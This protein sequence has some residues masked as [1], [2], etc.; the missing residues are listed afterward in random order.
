MDLEDLQP[1][2]ESSGIEEI[3]AVSLSFD[4]EFRHAND[5]FFKQAEQLEGAAWYLSHTPSL[6]R[7]QPSVP[8]WFGREEFRKIAS[9]QLRQKRRD[10]KLMGIGLSGRLQP[11]GR[12]ILHVEL[13]ESK[14]TACVVLLDVAFRRDLSSRFG[15]EPCDSFIDPADPGKGTARVAI[16]SE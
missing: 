11:V 13:D 2:V 12:I 7:H 5:S 1:L 14:F 16:A 4:L 6:S 15:F 8:L 9:T 3:E 10:R